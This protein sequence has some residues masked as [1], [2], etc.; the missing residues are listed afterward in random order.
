M[1]R[2]VLLAS[3]ALSVMGAHAADL[4]PRFEAKTVCQYIAAVKALGP[5]SRSDVT[6][7][8]AAGVMALDEMVRGGVLDLDGDGVMEKI[9]PDYDTGTMGGDAYSII[10]ADGTEAFTAGMG[11]EDGGFGSAFLS[12]AGRWYFVTFAAET[13][14][15]VSGAFTFAEGSLETVTACRFGND[16]VETMYG[17]A[18]ASQSDQEWCD[19]PARSEAIAGRLK[20][21][22][23]IDEATEARLAED[24]IA[25]L[26]ETSLQGLSGR[27]I[28]A[29]QGGPFA[30][31]KL[32]K[33][34]NSSGAGRGCAGSFFRLVEG[35][36]VATT[37][38]ASPLQSLL[39]RMQSGEDEVGVFNCVADVALFEAN[40]RFFLD[41]NSGDEPPVTDQ[42]LNHAFIEGVDGAAKE[43][44]RASYEVTPKIVW[45][46]PELSR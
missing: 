15:F 24:L 17:G 29:P 20:P 1:Q 32:W 45:E 42:Q 26:G 5:V 9:V 44:C 23:E 6:L 41:R 28:Y 39:N 40:G 33:V 19:G 18:D 43:I 13:G 8:S 3:A 21:V 11:M 10:K 27:E 35:E 7:P 46:A 4:P 2:A 22:A 12:F 16:T 25:S 31:L 37:L 34:S 36:G 14:A 30:G 38:S